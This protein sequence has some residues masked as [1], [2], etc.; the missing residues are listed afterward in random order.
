MAPASAVCL[1]SQDLPMKGDFQML[2]FGTAGTAQFQIHPVDAASELPAILEVYR[3]CE[4]FLALGPVGQASLAMVQADLAHSAAEG[5]VF[6]GIYDHASGLMLG[7]VDFMLSGFE[8]DP[9]RAFLSLLM[10]AVP[11]RSQG[12][13][14]AVVRLVEDEIR[15]A[16]QARAIK[17]GVQI[18]NPQAIRFWQRMAYRIISD[19]Q[20]FPDGT[21]AYQLWKDL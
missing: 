8:G 7:I 20:P 6:C 11:Y 2:L 4:D 1:P 21:V 13:G 15:R 9:S 12:L 17:S 3:Q 5:G 18:N 10:I 16:G 14:G 19:A